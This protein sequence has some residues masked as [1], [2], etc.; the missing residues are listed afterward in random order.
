MA[1]LCVEIFQILIY[2]AKLRVA[3]LASLRSAI[4]SK[5]EVD[6]LLAVLPAGV[7]TILTYLHICK[8]LFLSYIFSVEEK[9]ELSCVLPVL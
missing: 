7:K 1:K 5:I 6:N 2:D 4:F 3:L 8:F 9:N